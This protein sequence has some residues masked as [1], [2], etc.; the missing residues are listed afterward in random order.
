MEIGQGLS[1]SRRAKILCLGPNGGQ[2][3][4]SVR[5]YAEESGTR[6]KDLTFTIRAGTKERDTRKGGTTQRGR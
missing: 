6:L 1:G 5:D 4:Y 2:F 3:F